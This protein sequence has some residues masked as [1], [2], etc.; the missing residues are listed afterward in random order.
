[1]KISYILQLKDFTYMFIAGIFLGI[2]YGII[3]I[4]NKIKKIQ[5]LQVISDILFSIMAIIGVIIL[6]NKINYGE[7]R[8]FLII[9]Y[10]IGFAIER[11]SLGKL[12]AKGYKSVYNYIVKFSKAFYRSKIG[13]F[14]FK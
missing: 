1:M 8:S 2:I 7:I 10:I 11:I 3:N 9:G 14:L 4:P 13:R 12:F 6:I 5:I